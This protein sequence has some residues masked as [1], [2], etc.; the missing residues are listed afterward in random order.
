MCFT[1]CHALG[2]VTWCDPPMMLTGIGHPHSH[3]CDQVDRLCRLCSVTESNP[4]AF[5]RAWLS[6]R[7]ARDHLR[8]FQQ[9]RGLFDICDAC[10]RSD[11]VRCR[12]GM[13]KSVETSPTEAVSQ[14][15]WTKLWMRPSK[16]WISLAKVV[17]W[18]S[19]PPGSCESWTSPSVSQFTVGVQNLWLVHRT[20]TKI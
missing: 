6:L 5:P 2:C 14:N 13:E 12:M 11:A 1:D 18:H 7:L 9:G 10:D 19:H 8:P 17:N 20:L 4:T 16:L 3:S 15:L